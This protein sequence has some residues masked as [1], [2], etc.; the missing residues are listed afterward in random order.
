[1]DVDNPWQVE[2]IEAFYFLKCPECNFFTKEDKAFYNHAVENHSLC[3]V[4]FG[5]PAESKEFLVQRGVLNEDVNLRLKQIKNCD[6][7]YVVEKETEIV[8]KDQEV[9]NNSIENEGL[10]NN[11]IEPEDNDMIFEDNESR[12][13]DNEIKLEDKEIKLEDNE[14]KFED[15][16][17][18]F[19]IMAS[20]G[21]ACFINKII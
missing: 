16:E 3:F 10:P 5:K 18:K 1:M 21:Q 8:V 2:S 13:E 20:F 14:I 4:L 15:K 7:K 19:E 12:L 9:L 6:Q 17:I 11:E